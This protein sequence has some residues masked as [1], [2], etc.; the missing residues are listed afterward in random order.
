M[1]ERISPQQ[2]GDL[3]MD[4][5]EFEN[6]LK[7]V[8][9]DLRGCHDLG[10]GNIIVIGRDGILCAG[11][12]MLQHDALLLSYLSLLAREV[13]LR[14]YFVRMFILD[15]LLKRIRQ[16]LIDHHSDPNSIAKVRDMLNQASRDIILLQEILA[17]LRES[18][19]E[20]EDM[21]VPPD[22]GGKRLFKVL[23]V[24]TMRRDILLRCVDL[25]KLCEGTRAQ[26]KTLQQMTDVINTKQLE[27]VFDNVNDNTKFLVDASAANERSS[28]SLEVMQV[29]CAGSFAFDIVDRLSGGT[30]NIV[31][32]NWV[33]D[34]LVKPFISRPFLWWFL[35][36]LWFGLVSKLLL[37]FMAHLNQKAHGALT[38]RVKLNRSV[39]IERWQAYLAT[40]FTKVTDSTVESSQVIKKKQWSE[41]N[42]KLWGGTPP[43]LEV[44]Y[45]EQH[46]YLLSVSF[47][48]N[49]KRT[50]F[51]PDELLHT[52]NQELKAAGVWADD[53]PSDMH[54]EG[55]GA[56]RRRLTK[57]PEK[58]KASFT[59]RN[60]DTPQNI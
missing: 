32:P 28:A 5:G 33:E 18:L 38:L 27:E 34:L 19:V 55:S 29:I 52:F 59:P 17:Y 47:V 36:M 40:K 57:V 48:T 25:N 2:A 26:L 10:N 23:S 41:T 20:M 45:D 39:H 60:S 50:T 58:E 4:K 30:L 35:N 7:Q 3:F 24:G 49:S 11:V 42:T 16:L 22:H 15:D 46:G 56:P 1:A 14:S 37:S 6:E 13:F 12:D 44:A 43:V 54:T 21:A 31:V 9:G 8:I 53:P 51:G